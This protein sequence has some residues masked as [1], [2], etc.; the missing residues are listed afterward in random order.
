MRVRELD[1]N[2]C[3]ALHLHGKEKP[4][5]KNAPFFSVVYEAKG[6]KF[7]TQVPRTCAHILDFY[8]FA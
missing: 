2:S 7:C 1:Y 6:M 4:I 5:G 8:L 3:E